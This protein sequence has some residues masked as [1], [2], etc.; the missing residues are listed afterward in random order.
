MRLN[1][2]EGNE[3]AVALYEKVGFVDKWP[4]DDAGG[5]EMVR[6]LGG[7]GSAPVVGFGG[8]LGSG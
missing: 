5:W 2:L 1:V 6:F 3:E 7:G 4:D 8:W